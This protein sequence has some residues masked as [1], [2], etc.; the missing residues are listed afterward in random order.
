MVD[1]PV[2]HAGPVSVRQPVLRD[3]AEERHDICQGGKDE[4]RY[5][6]IWF[7]IVYDC[8]Q[9][10]YLFVFAL[11]SPWIII[12]VVTRKEIQTD[13]AV[14][15]SLS[16][17]RPQFGL[18]LSLSHF[19]HGERRSFPLI[20][21]QMRKVTSEKADQREKIKNRR[22]FKENA[23]CRQRFHSIRKKKV[24]EWKLRSLKTS[25]WWGRV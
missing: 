7:V 5:W 10:N 8:K 17:I 15:P 20:L 6:T 25:L 19:P 4:K 14:F 16:L 9:L 13:Y 11:Y 3:V 1:H 23:R 18:S 24:Y 2:H 12:F 21:P 22:D